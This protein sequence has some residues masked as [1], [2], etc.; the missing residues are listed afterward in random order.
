VP[1]VA[2]Y[3]RDSRRERAQ[4]R[5][6][7]E[8]ETARISAEN[9]RQRDEEAAARARWRGEGLY[10]LLGGVGLLLFAS[11]LLAILAIERHARVLEQAL[12]SRGQSTPIPAGRGEGAV[13]VVDASAATTGE[14]S[15]RS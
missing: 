9:T 14:R 11:L 6:H 3:V 7:W 2:Q 13:V 5:A 15:R 10:A 8:A 1:V 4:A 12:L